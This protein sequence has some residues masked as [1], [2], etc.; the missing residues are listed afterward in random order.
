MNFWDTYKVRTLRLGAN[1]E[2]APR[3]RYDMGKD[4]VRVSIISPAF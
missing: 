3:Y 4:L 1:V 2:S